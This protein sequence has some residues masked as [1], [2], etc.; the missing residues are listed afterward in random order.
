[1]S[2]KICRITLTGGNVRNHHFYLRDAASLLPADSIGGKN[3]DERALPITVRF[4]PG[5]TVETDVDGAKMIFRDR[6]AVRTF[7]ESAAAVEG[8]VVVLELTGP[9]TVEVTLEDATP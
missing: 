8:D 2:A 7:M 1:M 6:S 9:R 5:P 4:T 3:A